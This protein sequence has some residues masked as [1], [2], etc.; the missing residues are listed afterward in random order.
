MLKEFWEYN[1]DILSVKAKL[2]WL[3][4]HY[5]GAIEDFVYISY[6][7]IHNT[8][9]ITTYSI[10]LSIKELVREGMLI[11]D[12]SGKRSGYKVILGD[13]YDY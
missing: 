2:L 11:V 10:S 6:V 3:Y 13:D 8:T 5:L 12:R 9:G 4:F 7:G 1:A